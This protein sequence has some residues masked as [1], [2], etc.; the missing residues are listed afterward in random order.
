MSTIPQKPA[1]FSRKIGQSF[2][3]F[4]LVAGVVTATV[5]TII[6]TVW[7][8]IENPGGIFRDAAG[9]NWQFIFDTA[10]SWFVPTFIGI[11]LVATAGHLLWSL[12]RKRGR[13]GAN[14]AS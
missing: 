2:W 4:G 12:A 14:S 5:L 9:T 8:W 13:K 6:V 11:G 7:E 3:R 1:L 10:I